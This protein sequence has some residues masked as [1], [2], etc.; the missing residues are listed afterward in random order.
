ML[1]FTPI[2]ARPIGALPSVS[3]PSNA[4]TL[5]A[6]SGSY[7]VSGL[8]VTELINR[9][10]NASSGS[11]AVTGAAATLNSNKV[12]NSSSGSYSLTGSSATL[13]VKVAFVLTADNGSYALT[14]NA[15]E[16]LI[17]RVLVASN[18]TYSLTGALATVGRQITLR[19][20]SGSYNINL[21]VQSQTYVL[22]WYT[23]SAW[24]IL[25][26]DPVVYP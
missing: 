26:K 13:T 10:L 4:Y 6:S 18:G 22:K 16:V 20:N 24:Q 15:T 2:A 7:S 14:G 3:A 9:S 17:N 1:G 21:P 11:Y 12:L 23:G 19:A 8:D 5:D 25:Y